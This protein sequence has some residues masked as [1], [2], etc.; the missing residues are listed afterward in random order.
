MFTIVCITTEMAQA[1]ITYTV[2]VFVNTFIAKE[3]GVNWEDTSSNANVVAIEATIA[4][5]FG[6]AKS[7]SAAKTVK[8][9]DKRALKKDDDVKLHTEFSTN[10]LN[11]PLPFVVVDILRRGRLDNL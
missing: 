8:V 1:A 4:R 11:I 7:R 5:N 3:V 9:E 6:S 2:L 10:L